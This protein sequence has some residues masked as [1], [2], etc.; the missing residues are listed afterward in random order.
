MFAELNHNLFLKEVFS[1]SC[2]TE[3]IAFTEDLLF[4]TKAI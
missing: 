2:F 3:L 4:T 1:G